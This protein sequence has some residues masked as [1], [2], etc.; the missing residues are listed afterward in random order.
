[1]F[2]NMFMAFIRKVKTASGATAVQ[3]A[4]KSG[5]RVVR[6]EHIGSAHNSEDLEVLVSLAK[7][8][9]LAGQQPLF[10]S[11]DNLQI[12]LRQSC[13]RLLFQV[14][15]EQ[16]RRLGFSQLNDS[17]FAS[18]CIARIVEPTSKLDSLRVLADMGITSLS[19]SRLHR[20]LEQVVRDNYRQT[21]SKLCFNHVSG[22][23]LNLVLYDVTTLYFEVQEEDDYRK[24][25][26]SKERR[27]EPQIVIGLLVD[28]SGFPLSLQSFKGNTAETKTILP[29][30]E[31][32]RRQHD[33]GKV[34][35]VADAAMLSRVNLEALATSG[36][37]FIVGSRLT[38][39]PYDI[40]EFQKQTKSKFTD[41]QIFVVSKGNYT[42]IYQYKEKRA[43]LNRKN[44][45]AQVVKAQRMIKGIAPV[46]RNRFVT[47]ES[48]TKTLNQNLID[49]AYSLAGIKGYV[50][51]L[52]IPPQEIINAY[53][54][55]FN[56]EKSFRMAK[57][58]LKARP[59]FHRK[60]DVIEAHL[61]V[62]FAALAISRRIEKQT[63]LSIK[64][65][66]KTL[67]PIRSGT[68]VINGTGYPAE[69]EIPEDIHNLLKKLES[70]H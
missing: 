68:V 60:R 50:T 5:G 31:E 20:S 27:L 18:L 37:C 2:Y 8:R 45:E 25:G 17:D 61:T 66:V 54:E 34:T 47:L 49:K 32:F 23:N 33:L 9:L 38:K 69:P 56:V 40:S 52:S 67:R 14:L 51:N 12:K 16:Y 26:L 48:E 13:S 58:D 63:G 42:V 62:V 55:L 46:K 6:I 59:I 35:V 4:R 53:H 19:K 24:P 57:S 41:N 64:K 10:T 65:F 44:I 29:V 39:I 30:L 7:K 43:K 11:G 28:Q 3:I 70:G 21:I 36:Y 15:N 1:M 22:E